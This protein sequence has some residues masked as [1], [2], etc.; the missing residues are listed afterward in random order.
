MLL[1]FKMTLCIA[2]DSRNEVL[3]GVQK[4]GFNPDLYRMNA[5]QG[6]AHDPSRKKYITMV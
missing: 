1:I 3:T 2:G 5:L 4:L 6:L